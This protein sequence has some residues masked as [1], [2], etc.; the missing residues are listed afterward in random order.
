MNN[1]KKHFWNLFVLSSL[2]VVLILAGATPA[3]AKKTQTIK[4]AEIQKRANDFLM[5]TLSWRPD[6]IELFVNYKA[7]DMKL[8]EGLIDYDFQL[9]G[10]KN[11][12]G[13]VP[14][15]LLVK[16]DGVVR[17]RARLDAD[18]TVIYDVIKTTHLNPV[19]KVFQAIICIKNR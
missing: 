9:P 4:A 5:Q 7:G 19:S 11:R 6:Q 15:S 2:M 13:K 12:V 14:F 8:P 17:K 1:Y 10:R 3:L 18:I 16:V